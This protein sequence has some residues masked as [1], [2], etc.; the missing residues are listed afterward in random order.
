MKPSLNSSQPRRQS[1]GR[2]GSVSLAPAGTGER[3]GRG[4]QKPQPHIMGPTL[5]WRAR[6]ESEA[7]S[8]TPQYGPGCGLAQAWLAWAFRRQRRLRASELKPGEERQGACIALQCTSV[9]A[10]LESSD[11]PST[12]PRTQL[13]NIQSLPSTLPILHNLRLETF[14]THDCRPV[15]GCGDLGLVT[16]QMTVQG[17]GRDFGP[18]RSSPAPLY[19]W[20]SNIWSS[21]FLQQDAKYIVS[22]SRLRAPARELISGVAHQQPSPAFQGIT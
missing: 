19:G 4:Q 20:I 2:D 22:K 18:R 13:G 15:T 1:A 3:I 11:F 12:S 10:E 21:T 5:D 6:L 9:R 17:K 16:L 14:L 8:G 7:E